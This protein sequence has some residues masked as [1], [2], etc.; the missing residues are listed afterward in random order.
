MM[1]EISQQIKKENAGLSH[2]VS[3]ALKTLFDQGRKKIRILLAEDDLGS[4]LL[5]GRLLERLNYDIDYAENGRGVIDMWERG[6]YDLILMDVGMP[7]IDGL[8]A[9]RVI[10]EKEREGGGHIPIM[11][12]TAHS[13]EK[14][15]ERCLSAGMDAYISKP[16]DLR[17][18]LEMIEQLIID[19]ASLSQSAR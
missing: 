4:Q 15:E 8:G 10:R 6:D 9:T 3:P 1:E 14:D 5:L 18:C 2:D 17:K 13:A 7:G 11:A 12:I 16:I 19:I